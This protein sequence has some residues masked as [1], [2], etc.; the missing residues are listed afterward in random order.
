MAG[1]YSG[2][3]GGDED[4]V[5]NLVLNGQEAV[6]K[7]VESFIQMLNTMLR[8]AGKFNISDYFGTA[9]SE[10]DSV[11]RSLELF[12][13]D[14]DSA[15]NAGEFLKR[16]NSYIAQFDGTLTE[17]AGHVQSLF[18]DELSRAYYRTF[19]EVIRI[20]ERVAPEIA[21]AF[22]PKALQDQFAGIQYVVND[23][24]LD[25]K[26][27]FEAVN[28]GDTSRLREEIATLQIALDD[29][30]WTIENLKRQLE[31]LDDSHLQE[32]LAQYQ[33]TARSMAREFKALLSANGV[34][35]EDQYKFRK[36]FNDIESGVTTVKDAF[37]E[38]KKEMGHLFST[39]MDANGLEEMLTRIETR[40]NA[41]IDK[42]RQASGASTGVGAATGVV[43]QAEQGIQAAEREAE[44][45]D[46]VTQKAAGLEALI[47]GLRAVAEGMKN[48]GDTANA[49]FDSINKLVDSLIKLGDVDE[50]KL[51][52]VSMI[53]SSLSGISELKVGA[54]SVD[55]LIKL[56]SAINDI[57]DGKGIDSLRS[58]ANVR[59]DNFGT[60]KVSKAAIDNLR[61]GLP[62]IAKVK[63]ANLQALADIP[64]KN[65]E[66]LKVSKASIDNL[67]QLRDLFQSGSFTLDESNLSSLSDMIQSA[68]EKAAKNIKL[69]IDHVE[70]SDAAQRQ[71]A[72][73][74]QRAANVGAATGGTS[75]AAAG[76]SKSVNTNEAKFL[77]EM[78]QLEEQLNAWK[79]KNQG[80]YLR[81]QQAIDQL[82]QVIH[83][84]I[85]DAQGVLDSYSESL[86]AVGTATEET[87]GE[88]RAAVASAT[89]TGTDQSLNDRARED[90]NAAWEL[91]DAENA[92]AEATAKATQEVSEQVK[93]RQMARAWEED[94][95]IRAREERAAQAENSAIQRN[96]DAYN[97]QAEAA[98]RAAERRAEAAE[99]AAQREIAAQE[100]AAY[101]ADALR[102]SQIASDW[103][104]N[105]RRNTEALQAE[106]EELQRAA[107]YWD[108]YCDSVA[109]ANNAATIKSFE[110]SSA[111]KLKQEKIALEQ[112][113][114]KYAEYYELESKKINAVHS[115]KLDDA[116]YYR[117]QA[118]AMRGLLD[119][120][121]TL[122]P[123]LTDQAR[124]TD[125]VT[126]AIEKYNA[127]A[128]RGESKADEAMAKRVEEEARA[129][130]TYKKQL[131]ALQL[132]TA[133]GKAQFDDSAVQ[134]YAAAL[135]ELENRYHAIES[136]A[137][138]EKAEAVAA[139]E[140][141]RQAVAALREE[142]DQQAKS[143]GSIEANA[144]RAAKLSDKIDLWSQKNPKAYADAKEQI[145]EWIATLQSAGP[146]SKATLDEISSGFQHVAAQ[147]KL[148]GNNGQ[149]FFQQLQA[150]WSKFGG[151]S[152]VSRSFMMVI[153]T[154]KQAVTAVKEVDAAMTELRKVTDLT[155]QSYAKLYSRMTEMASKVGSKVS[156]VINSVADFSRLGFSAEEAVKLSEAA[157]VYFNVGD[158][159]ESVSTAT[160]S[161]IST[162]KA[163]GIEADNVMSIVDKFNEVGNNFAISSSGIGEALQRSASALAT[164][165]NTIDE[166]IGLIVA[167]NDVVQNPES[168]GENYLRPAA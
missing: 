5:I 81:N 128:T 24:G 51:E 65:F 122:L 52:R 17:A 111:E 136:A 97:S 121:E 103:A 148:A 101:K 123:D 80:A 30:N 46:T 152:L 68:I 163:F 57:G 117:E 83:A 98:E 15:G 95:S 67:M 118:N 53:M 3:S 66:K 140:E 114:A 38:A 36:Y 126:A 45:I 18:G 138:N 10:I 23:L 76:S 87:I 133:G 155:E 40:L 91:V 55:N 44:A 56:V 28:A 120:L 71:I 72:G 32:Q 144:A 149:T 14:M 73:T 158:G 131:D 31:E 116:D 109:A 160:E 74:A 19:D 86:T 154:F 6:K 7:D 63:A 168:V 100:E 164:A 58:L 26:R 16:Y 150:G 62:E 99:Q 115:G 75:G 119:T 20:A 146:I 42:E 145:D 151:W 13:D 110:K 54:A 106:E 4:L 124:R 22:D 69:T 8:G 159:I 33:D 21:N 139:F 70:F 77:R 112:V 2:R 64:W 167:A 143:F 125:E 113:V 107:A 157:L 89:S 93:Q 156:D 50:T 25:V 102:Q 161:L 88:L 166:S 34:S 41:V 96:M 134:M 9:K 105:E 1:K 47:A 43:A 37:A 129:L 90:I 84:T 147:E 11:R 141:Q 78:I 130:E 165:G 12:L 61:T 27:V 94:A 132:D 108:S 60:L 39:P 79:T 135:T 127:A 104:D 153:R 48:T 142:L 137:L 92:V 29:A 49:A 59:F 85:A 162:I 35:S 82:G